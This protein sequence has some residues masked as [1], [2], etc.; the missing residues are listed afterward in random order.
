LGKAII[1]FGEERFPVELTIDT[2]SDGPGFIDFSHE[3]RDTCD[4]MPISYRI[5]LNWSRPRYGGR[6]YWFCCPGSGER[7]LKLFLPLGGHRF[8]SREGYRLGYACQREARSDR[9]MRKARKLHR[10]LGGDGAALG[11]DPPGKPK[12][13]HWRTY[14]RKLEAM[15]DRRRPG[16]RALDAVTDAASPENRLSL[17]I[18]ARRGNGVVVSLDWR[19][20]HAAGTMM[21]A[22]SDTV[23]TVQ[24]RRSGGKQVVQVIHQQVAV[25][26]GVRPL[27]RAPSRAEARPGAIGGGQ[28]ENWP[29]TL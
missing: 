6:R 4:P 28:S 12:G 9:L 10:A 5:W 15:D 11:Q 24:R 17:L 23:L 22:F 2:R 7:A 14:E 8:L 27:S 18:L 25:E 16:Q 1:H 21:A 26:A 19:R 20:A 3:T 29:A 13:M